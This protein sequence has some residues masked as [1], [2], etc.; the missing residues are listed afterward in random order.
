MLFGRARS[1]ELRR[2]VGRLM[3]W[4]LSQSLSLLHHLAQHRRQY[5]P[6]TLCPALS[7]RQ[8]LEEIRTPPEHDNGM[9]LEPPSPQ[10]TVF[11]AEQLIARAVHA[12]YMAAH[13]VGL[14]GREMKAMACV[15]GQA[16][17]LLD[18]VE[19]ARRALLRQAG[20]RKI[21]PSAERV[22]PLYRC[23]ARALPAK[24][25]GAFSFAPQKKSPRGEGAGFKSLSRRGKRGTG[26]GGEGTVH[27]FCI[28]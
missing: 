27:M 23:R 3:T 19:A 16:E 10:A 24:A 7:P 6:T 25:G 20:R 13:G 15:L 11:R 12:A 28:F 5:L 1:L 18:N 14:D 4:L 8:S 26:L 21:A 17:D 2:S 9:S 22:P